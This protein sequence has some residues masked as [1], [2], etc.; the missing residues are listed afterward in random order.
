MK[1][2][3]LLFS[4][5]LS[6]Q[7]VAQTNTDSL[8]NAWNTE[9]LPDQDRMDALL[10]LARQVG[11][12]NPD[13]GIV[14]GQALM[15]FASAVEDP[16]YQGRALS[17]QAAVYGSKQVFNKTLELGNQA[18]DYLEQ[19]DQ[20]LDI[21]FCYGLLGQGNLANE[22]FME[23]IEV[24][25]K[26]LTIYQEVSDTSRGARLQVARAHV[27]LGKSYMELGDYPQAVEFLTEARTINE[28]VK[29]PYIEQT[30][31]RI[32]MV[33]SMRQ[34][35]YD[36]TWD[37]LEENRKLVEQL[38]S[39]RSLGAYYIN[40]GTYLLKIED[41][42]R[43]IEYTLKGIELCE[44]AGVKAF[45]GNG[46]SN[47][48]SFYAAQQK[49]ELALEHYQKSFTIREE[50]GDRS[51]T[52][53]VG[54]ANIQNRQENYA[55]AVPY[56]V[57]ALEIAEQT[58]AIYQ[59]QEAAGV[60]YTSYEGIGQYEK[61][62]A[63]HK[64]FVS[65]RD[66]AKTE[67]NQRASLQQEYE[68]EYDK[69]KAL[70]D[71][72][73]EQAKTRQQYISGGIGLGLLVVALL[74]LLLFQRL[75]STRR[76]KLLIEV[77]K[78]KAE[79]SERF[80]ER[81]LA[82]MSHEIRTPMHAISGMVNILK[83]N[84]HSEQQTPFLDAMGTSARNLLVIL[85]D[86]L[87]LSKIEAGK[88]HIEQIP[89]NPVEVAE[90]VIEMLRFK[91]EEK[92]LALSMTVEEDFP[93]QVQGDPTR[94]NQILTNLTGNAIKFTEEGSVRLH[95]QQHAGQMQFSIVDTG[96]GIP[97]EKQGE[98]FGSFEQADDSTTR[99][100]GGTGLGL[101]ITRQLVELQEGTIALESEVDKGST[102]RVSL[103]LVKTKESKAVRTSI[104]ES[105]LK[106]M[107]AEMKGLRILLAEDDP[108]NVMVVGDDLAWYI[109]EVQIDTA[110]N[111]LAA[112]EMYQQG[113]YDLILMD[114]R[115]PNMNGYEAAK[116]IRK[117]DQN[118]P[119]IALT[120]SLLESEIQLCHEV[121]M[122]G[123]IPKPYQ[124]DQLVGTM[125]EVVGE[126][127]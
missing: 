37:Y 27:F 71:Q 98:I 117:I 120:A 118:I 95:L 45:V 43:A 73:F 51:I 57:K 122:N 7:A 102:F 20:K 101:S 103:P 92:G 111:G 46:H 100:Y 39:K 22:R 96:I 109:P 91:A 6:L 87:D 3:V 77:A 11:T 112:I 23:A 115:M 108:F 25:Q 15:E 89:I 76:E 42:D 58:G 114:M 47:V 29:E 33:I 83:R 30:V 104:P 62:L 65:M 41:L 125:Y 86:V 66:S 56:G 72:A 40:A 36:L 16:L 54:L 26:Q 67:E 9:S 60:L 12:Q 49:Y 4:L 97:E 106:A 99:D 82:N 68:Y 121:G 75:R 81:F 126:E 93:Q 55:Q 35:D 5:I 69:Q 85:N 64:Q 1:R 50:I 24:L 80:K 44:E 110:E 59:I 31:L 63:L 78:D 14:L 116:E 17:L 8:W 52:H 18:L 48:A 105:Q 84:Q 124:L 123:Y 79:Q 38:Q 19:T 28:E 107:G 90:Q 127:K 61:A 113:G 10:S 32:L 74:A 53:L 94:L 119:I 70:D 2:I 34:E 21:A 88:L 13:S